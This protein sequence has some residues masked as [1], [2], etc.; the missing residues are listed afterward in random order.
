MNRHHD[1]APFG[2]LFTFVYSQ[3][4]CS[5][6]LPWAL[7]PGCPVP[8]LASSVLCTGMLFQLHV[9]RHPQ[10]GSEDLTDTIYARAG[11]MADG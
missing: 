10:A 4:S 1:M 6:T 2:P 7:G 8:V 3:K 11:A 9:S 5:H